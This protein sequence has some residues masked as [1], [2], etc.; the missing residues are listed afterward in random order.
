MDDIILVT[1][2]V[3]QEMWPIIIRNGHSLVRWF[4]V[5]KQIPHIPN[6]QAMLPLSKHVRKKSGTSLC[7]IIIL[8]NEPQKEENLISDTVRVD[9]TETPSQYKE[10]NHL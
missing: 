8:E 5:T 4:I 1:D 7:T 6:R 2:Q 9:S 3:Q 10:G